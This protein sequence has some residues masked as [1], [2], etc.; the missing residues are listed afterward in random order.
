M[1]HLTNKLK[2]KAKKYLRRK[3]RVNK[4]IKSQK[5][6]NRLIINKSNLYISGQLIDIDG[7]VIALTND[8]KAKG[9]TKTEKA[10]TAGEEFAKT[11]KTKKIS[12][13]T[14]DRNGYLYH[15]RIKAFADGLRKGGIKL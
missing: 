11:L 5:P 15:G 8:K 4:N 1:S 6:K 12:Q 9:K 14:F 7:K 2:E 3:A 10:F 13:I